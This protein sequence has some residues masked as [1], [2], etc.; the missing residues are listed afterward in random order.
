[1][2]AL[3]HTLLFQRADAA[4]AWG[5]GEA[6]PLGQI[7]IGDPPIALQ[8]GKQFSIDRVEI[9]Q[10]YAPFAQQLVGMQKQTLRRKCRS[11]NLIIFAFQC[12]ALQREAVQRS[13]MCDC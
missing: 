7:N 8:F 12:P 5:S 11:S 1:M 6:H 2:I 4:Q 9:G 10:V 3:D 13:Y